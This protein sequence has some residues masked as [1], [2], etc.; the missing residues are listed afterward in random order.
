MPRRV[1]G[2]PGETIGFRPVN[3][4]NHPAGRPITTPQ[5]RVLRRPVEFALA[6]TVRVMDQP[7]DGVV[8]RAHEG[9][10]ESFRRRVFGA[11]RGAGC[12]ADD[13]PVNTSVTNAV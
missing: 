5:I 2:C 12:T 8:S 7:V 4:F 6:A 1:P 11:H 10:S 13:L 3:S 9:V